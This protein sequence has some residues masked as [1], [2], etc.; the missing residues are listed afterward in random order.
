MPEPEDAVGVDLKAVHPAVAEK[1]PV[2][3]ACVLEDP[4]VPS[5]PYDRVPPRH[6]RVGDYDATL[7][8]AAEDT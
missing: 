2:G 1:R 7:W 5:R 4:A 6:A 8:I 3:A